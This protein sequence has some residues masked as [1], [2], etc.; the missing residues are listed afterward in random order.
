MHSASSYTSWMKILDNISP[1][2]DP[3]RSIIPLATSHQLGVEPLI[4]TLWA[5][6]SHP[7]SAYLTSLCPQA[8]HTF[9]AFSGCLALR[10]SQFFIDNR[11]ALQTCWL[12]PSSPS[13]ETHLTPWMWM[14]QLLWA[15]LLLPWALH[16]L[17]QPCWGT[18]RSRR[19]HSL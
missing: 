10:S 14:F 12:A 4:T 16:L 17:P 7:F 18:Q 3:W 9:S 8:K 11:V 13:G 5:W 15:V 6:Q 1:S 19:W 2:I